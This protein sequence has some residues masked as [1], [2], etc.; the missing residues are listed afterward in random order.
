M[1]S[2]G[3]LFALFSFFIFT[4][5]YIIGNWVILPKIKE[6]MKE[7]KEKSKGVNKKYERRIRKQNEAIRMFNEII[8][9]E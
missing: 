2:F 6:K 4:F 9:D 7:R 1:V 8:F 5:G 3:E